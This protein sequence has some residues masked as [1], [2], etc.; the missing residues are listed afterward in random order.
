MATDPCSIEIQHTG[1]SGSHF[2]KYNAWA[3]GDDHIDWYGA[4]AGQGDYLG[5]VKECTICKA[6]GKVQLVNLISKLM[7]PCET[8]LIVL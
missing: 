3:D 6:F 5:K 2:D 7:L 1:Q 4:E 8:R